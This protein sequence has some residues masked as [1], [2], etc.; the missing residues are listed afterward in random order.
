MWHRVAPGLAKHFHVICMDLRGYGW[1][2]APHPDPSHQTYSKRAMG[3]DVLA[4]L[5][6]FGLSARRSAAMTAVGASPTGWR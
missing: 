5:D 2:S 3:E 6:H 4:V 1:S